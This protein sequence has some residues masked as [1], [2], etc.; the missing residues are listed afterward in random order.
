MR[1]QNPARERSQDCR[2]CAATPCKPR[3]RRRTSMRALRPHRASRELIPLIPLK[4]IVGW[5]WTLAPHSR[6]TETFGLRTPTH[7]GGRSPNRG[8]AQH[9][10]P[11]PWF[12][13][14]PNPPFSPPRLPRLV[15]AQGQLRVGCGSVS[16]VARRS[17]FRRTG[18]IA[19]SLQSGR[20]S[21]A[22]SS[23]PC[24]RGSSLYF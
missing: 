1:C 23:P 20:P 5:P 22:K 11:K 17:G 10:I 13:P 2:T 8:G 3:L 21:R 18:A 14:A 12:V 24:T 6:R 9:R 16:V 15:G 4:C 7:N 19:C